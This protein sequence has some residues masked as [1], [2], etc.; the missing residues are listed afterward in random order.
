MEHPNSLEP[1]VLRLRL[2]MTI[3]NLGD[4]F[5]PLKPTEGLNGAPKIAGTAGPSA[6][7]R[8]TILNLGDV[9]F[10]LKPTEG[11]NGAPAGS[12]MH[13]IDVKSYRKP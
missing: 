12:V 8:M 5:F 7:F 3:L 13:K 10:P 11:L 2:R 9:F 6:S 4:V 1:Q